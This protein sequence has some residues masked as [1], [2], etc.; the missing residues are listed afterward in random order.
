MYKPAGNAFARKTKIAGR[1]TSI[2][3][4]VR[5]L[6][7]SFLGSVAGRVIFVCTIWSAADA[8]ARMLVTPRRAASTCGWPALMP[9]SQGTVVSIHA[10]TCWCAASRNSGEAGQLR[11]NSWT[12]NTFSIGLTL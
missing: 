4:C 12:P 9:R 7:S 5:V 3:R 6:G 11:L 2:W 10:L 8:R 1:M